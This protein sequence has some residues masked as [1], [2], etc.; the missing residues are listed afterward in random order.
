MTTGASS[1]GLSHG[2]SVVT[3]TVSSGSAH[4]LICGDSDATGK[5]FNEKVVRGST[6]DYLE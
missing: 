3:V 5:A 4:W 2:P 6:I 1:S